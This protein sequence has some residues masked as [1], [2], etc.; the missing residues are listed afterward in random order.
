MSNGPSNPQINLTRIASKSLAGGHAP[1]PGSG[2]SAKKE[3]DKYKPVT[4]HTVVKRVIPVTD[5]KPADGADDEPEGEPTGDA[6]PPAE[7]A[8]AEKDRHAKWREAQEAKRAARAQANVDAAAKRQVL[9]KELLAKNDLAGA[10]KA[11]GMPASE[12]VTLVNQAALGLKPEEEAP[13]KLT[14][15]EQRVADETAF[16]EEMKAFRAEQE[17]FRN[18]QAM[19]GF[20]EKNIR[21]VLADKEAYEMIHAAGVEDIET[22][23]Y[24]YMNQH[25]FD[26]S[27]KDASGKITKPGEV[28]NAKDVLD[29]IEENL[30]KQHT[31]TLERARGLKKVS[32]YFAPVGDAAASEE[33]PA[34]RDE[35]DKAGSTSLTSA[36]R[37]QVA[38][39]IAEL[40]AEG[41]AEETETPAEP[42]PANPA[43]P[44]IVRPPS[45]GANIRASKLVG[46]RLT[47]AE[48]LAR[49]RAEE[50]EAARASLARRR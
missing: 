24:R 37:R 7:T 21:P 41:A 9:A 30:L 45:N 34:T 40:E 42:P 5:F 50:E 2:E 18:Q 23:A 31:A 6:A 39:A 46:V 14:P 16:R 48:K 3:A 44:K 32:K 13:K 12:L 29:A 25:Y 36:R 4:E 26:T 1:L 22:Y 33:T 10:A 27:E 49:V 20:V 43:A 15:E 28:L 47:A 8:A 35:I 11:L 17:A 19:T 38:Q